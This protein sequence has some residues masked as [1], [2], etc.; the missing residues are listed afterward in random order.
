[1]SPCLFLFKVYNQF[2]LGLH[3][4]THPLPISSSIPS[5]PNEIVLS[6]HPPEGSN[7][8]KPRLE[9]NILI[10][11][12]PCAEKT[13]KIFSTWFKEGFIRNFETLE[14]QI[15]HIDSKDSKKVRPKKFIDGMCWR[16]ASIGCYPYALHHKMSTSWNI[17][18]IKNI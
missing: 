14:L 8:S 2:C 15:V 4:N 18:L 7:T 1:M 16:K 9:V 17:W 13:L 6:T 12:K 5:L 11:Y 10:F 3:T